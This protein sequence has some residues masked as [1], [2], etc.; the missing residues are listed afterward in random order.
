MAQCL[1]K[2]LKQ[3]R[4]RYRRYINA[5]KSVA[6]DNRQEIMRLWEE[7]EKRVPREWYNEML[8]NM[9]LMKALEACANDELKKKKEV[10]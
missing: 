10:K 5:S 3:L 9:S 1:A 8:N 2:E 6:N 4:R 7:I